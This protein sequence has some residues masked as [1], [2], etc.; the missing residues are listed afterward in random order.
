MMN[1]IN[2]PK[3]TVITVAYNAEGMKSIFK[4]CLDSGLNLKYD[5][6]KKYDNSCFLRI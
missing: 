3:V 1:K 5:D 4:Q 2:H 6:L